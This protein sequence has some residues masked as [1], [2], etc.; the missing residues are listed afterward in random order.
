M[1]PSTAVSS[2]TALLWLHCCT[3]DLAQSAWRSLHNALRCGADVPL[4]IPE[5]SYLWLPGKLP[6]GPLYRHNT[7]SNYKTHYSWRSGIYK[8]RFEGVISFSLCPCVETDPSVKPENSRNQVLP[9]A[10]GTPWGGGGS[11]GIWVGEWQVVCSQRTGSS[12]CR[13]APGDCEPDLC[14]LLLRCHSSSSVSLL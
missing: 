14:C 4:G 2:G 1:P 12:R 6:L 13:A 7:F 8:G 10:A 9:A 3:P 5:T 11:T